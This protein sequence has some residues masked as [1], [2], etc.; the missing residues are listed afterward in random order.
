MCLVTTNLA[1]YDAIGNDVLG[2]R[3]SLVDA[4][5]DATAYAAEVHPALAGVARKLDLDTQDFW[6][7]P[8]TLLIYHHS[9][10][11]PAGQDLLEA[12]QNKIVIKY[13]NITPPRFFQP[14]SE[15][16][17][18][19]CRAGEVANFRV[20]N[21]RRAYFWGDSTFNC[22]DLQRYG[23][24]AERCR[25]LAPFHATEQMDPLPLDKKLLERYAKRRGTRILFAGGIKPNKGHLNLLRT[26]AEIKRRHDA[27]VL[28]FL[29]GAMDSRLKAYQRHLKDV[30]ETHG[31]T[32]NVVFPGAVS[33]AEMK[34]YFFM[35]DVFLCLSEHEGFCVPL[36]E[37]MYFR[38]P[39]VAS[40]ATA[41]AETAGD[42]GMVWMEEDIGCYAES[43][44]AC[45]EEPALRGTLK[46][47]G[48]RRFE[49]HFAGGVLGARLAELV[50]EA[51]A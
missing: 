11:W 34:T 45:V 46:T 50:D 39:I 8:D 47:A 25:V 41:V 18:G 5:F 48:R 22:R 1:P 4:G 33:A 6:R 32:A 44:A 9:M 10:G 36:V 42:A 23:A 15:T 20:A 37:A 2:M 49:E 27:D 14:Y 38:V 16:Y 24:P 26:V 13:H 17:T 40:G 19:A 7:D 30:M 21:H 43:V 31:I 29:P 35:S 12:S 28:L 3:A 51:L